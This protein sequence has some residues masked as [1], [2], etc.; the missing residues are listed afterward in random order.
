M[1]LCKTRKSLHTAK[2]TVNTVKRQCTEWEKMFARQISDKG[3]IHI[4]NT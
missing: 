3:L 4:Q 1:G 2:K